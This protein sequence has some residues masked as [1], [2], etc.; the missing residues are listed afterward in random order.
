VGQ[1]TIRFLILETDKLPEDVISL[2]AFDN[3]LKESLLHILHV[4][5]FLGD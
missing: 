2:E 4:H 3:R 5:R 1:V